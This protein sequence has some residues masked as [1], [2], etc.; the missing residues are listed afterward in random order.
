MTIQVN[1]QGG[2]VTV[3]CG[4]ETVVVVGTVIF[5]SHGVQPATQAG[6]AF[7]G[8]TDGVSVPA[9]TD[10]DPFIIRTGPGQTGIGTFVESIVTPTG[11]V[12]LTNADLYALFDEP[13]RAAVTSSSVR[14][15]S[16]LGAKYGCK[17]VLSPCAPK[18]PSVASIADAASFPVFH[19]RW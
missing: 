13:I 17:V 8:T 6:P 19:K 14:A 15:I 3:S 10:P 18:A 5:E 7:T 2:V 16:D 12:T 9:S 1:D 11:P 4:S